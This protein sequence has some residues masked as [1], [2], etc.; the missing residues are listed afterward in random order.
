MVKFTCRC[1]FENLLWETHKELED[2]FRLLSEQSL[3][4][5]CIVQD[6]KIV[7]VNPQLIEILGY[8]LEFN[9]INDLAK[10]VV[11]ENR[12]RFLLRYKELT[13]RKLGY[14]IDEFKCIRSIDRKPVHIEVCAVN[15]TYKGKPA[16]LYTFWILLIEKP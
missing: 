14:I 13:E 10:S 15:T 5:V 8:P 1:D 3:I 4:G 12:Q 11:S 7:Y 9:N 2:R 6:E 16:V